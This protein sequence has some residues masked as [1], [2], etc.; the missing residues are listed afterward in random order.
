MKAKKKQVKVKDQDNCKEN[1]NNSKKKNENLD[2]KCEEEHNLNDNC[3]NAVSKPLR[4]TTIH[5]A[6]EYMKG[7]EYIIRGYR[8]NFDSSW[9]IFKR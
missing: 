8:L 4:I 7:N 3:S 2:L 9:K 1:N 5:E 6:Q